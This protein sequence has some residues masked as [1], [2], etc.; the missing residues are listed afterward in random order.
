MRGLKLLCVL[1][2]GLLGFLGAAAQAA[3][4]DIPTTYRAF[5]AA[6]NSR[7][8]DRIRPF[9]QNRPDFLWVSDGYSYWGTQAVLDRMARFQTAALWR[10]E[11]DMAQAKLVPLGAD[12][13]YLHLPLK[14]TFGSEAA[15]AHYNFLVSI[16]WVRAEG[17]WKI[18]ALLTTLA[19]ATP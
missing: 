12:S 4:P 15:P 11:P 17:S 13:A 16:L 10:A 1:G 5:V 19:H 6:Q 14:L 9:L 18:A 7:D 2:L 8:I 3:E